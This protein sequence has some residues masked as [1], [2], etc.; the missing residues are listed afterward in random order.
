M[1]LRKIQLSASNRPQSWVGI[2]SISEA[3]DNFL[4]TKFL[5]SVSGYFMDDSD[6]DLV[7]F[8]FPVYYD[9]IIANTDGLDYVLTHSLDLEIIEY[10]HD[11]NGKYYYKPLEISECKP[12][13]N[14][15]NYD[16]LFKLSGSYEYNY[17]R[18]EVS[19][20]RGHSYFLGDSKTLY[21]FGKTEKTELPLFICFLR[22]L[23]GIN[24][25]EYIEL[26][27][28]KTFELEW[29]ELCG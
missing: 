3:G 27:R 15:S 29:L 18:C 13:R 19:S 12:K 26:N 23:P 2:R 22:K 14:I 21:R 4:I 6:E 28:R 7:L 10:I 9:M 24:E 8:D 16:K 5:P 17:T 11:G 1:E 25:N 20:I